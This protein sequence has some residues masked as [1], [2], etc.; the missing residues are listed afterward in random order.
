M[1]TK[2]LCMS[3]FQMEFTSTMICRAVP[4]DMILVFLL[5]YTHNAIDLFSICIYLAKKCVSDT[6]KAGF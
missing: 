3:A 6:R 5:V 1:T 4:K 2:Y